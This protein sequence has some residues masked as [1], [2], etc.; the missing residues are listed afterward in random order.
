MAAI[1]ERYS[2]RNSITWCGSSFSEIDVKPRMSLNRM[3]SSAR[4]PPTLI[5]DGSSASCATYSG[6]TY[7]ENIS[8][9]CRLCRPSVM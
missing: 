3:V 9:I 5:L 6:A 4:R 1:S 7:L 2:F 8:R